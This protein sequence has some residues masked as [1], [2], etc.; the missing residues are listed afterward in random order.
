MDLQPVIASVPS[1]FVILLFFAAGMLILPWLLGLNYT[2]FSLLLGAIPG[3]IGTLVGIVNLWL[4]R[5]S[6]E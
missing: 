6:G 5:R 2:L 1:I 3:A 4:E